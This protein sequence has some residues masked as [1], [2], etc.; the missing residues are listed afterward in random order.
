M[1]FDSPFGI[2]KGC[3][4]SPVKIAVVEIATMVMKVMTVV[5]WW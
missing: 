3:V 5:M 2:C 4:I 1:C